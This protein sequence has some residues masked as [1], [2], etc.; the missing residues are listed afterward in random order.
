[1]D[2]KIRLQVASQL[3]YCMRENS[4]FPYG[5]KG[6]D[7]I[8]EDMFKQQLE[9]ARKQLHDFQKARSFRHALDTFM[10]NWIFLDTSDY[11]PKFLGPAF[12]SDDLKDWKDWMKEQGMNPE[13]IQKVLATYSK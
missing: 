7:Q 2:N 13:D 11:L 5:D 3:F 9:A 6:N 10:P 12:V 8:T 1:M 4:Y